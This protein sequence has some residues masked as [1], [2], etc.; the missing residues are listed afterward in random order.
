M[1]QWVKS[2]HV[3][4]MAW[5]QISRTHINGLS[6]ALDAKQDPGSPLLF[7]VDPRPDLQNGLSGDGCWTQPRTPQITV[8]FSLVLAGPSLYGSGFQP[9]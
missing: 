3:N 5:V 8:T 9:S 7:C 4:L 2:Y 6:L 1:A